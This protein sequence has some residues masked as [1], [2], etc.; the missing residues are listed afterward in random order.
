MA[1]Y[2]PDLFLR[3]FG[4]SDLSHSHM[5]VGLGL[6]K[7]TNQQ[8]SKQRKLNFK[9]LIMEETDY[10]QLTTKIHEKKAKYL[11]SILNI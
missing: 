7:Q 6:K 1:C 11:F 4:T 9:R 2:V 8:K 10:I 3:S 5:E